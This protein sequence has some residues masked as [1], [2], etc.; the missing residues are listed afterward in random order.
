MFVLDL[1]E[2]AYGKGDVEA[3]SKDVVPVTPDGDGAGLPINCV[4]GVCN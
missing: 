3:L 2:F 1:G 4:P